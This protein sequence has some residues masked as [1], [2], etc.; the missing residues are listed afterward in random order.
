MV[1]IHFVYVSNT[2]TFQIHWFSWSC[3]QTLVKYKH[4]IFNFYRICLLCVPLIMFKCVSKYLCTYFQYCN[5]SRDCL[6]LFS[7]SNSFN[8]KKNRNRNIYQANTKKN[9]SDVKKKCVWSVDAK[10]HHGMAHKITT[11]IRV[12]MEKKRQIKWWKEIK[13]LINKKCKFTIAICSLPHTAWTLD[14]S[15]FLSWESIHIHS[16]IL[17]YTSSVFLFTAISHSRCRTYM[18]P[19]RITRI[20][21]VTHNN[22]LNWFLNDRNNK[23]NSG[24]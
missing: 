13:I 24:M 15:F 3:R 14:S 21:R 7:Q 10:P 12:R 8:E 6:N 5:R 23:Q 20:N 17:R 11:T 16:S 9:A 2:K 4:F 19:F 1:F 22:E 18:N